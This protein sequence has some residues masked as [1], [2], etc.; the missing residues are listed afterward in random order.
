MIW[1][2]SIEMQPQQIA[3]R[4]HNWRN[5]QIPECTWSIS[6]NAPFRTEM[7]IFLQNLEH[8]GIG[9]ISILGFVKLTV[10]HWKEF[11][12]LAF[13]L[14]WR[15]MS[16]I[17]SQIKGN[18][19]FSFNSCS[20]QLQMENQSSVSSGIS[21]HIHILY[22]PVLLAL[23]EGNPMV[24]DRFPLQ[25][26]SK[27]DSVSNEPCHDVMTLCS[28]TAENA[29]FTIVVFSGGAK[30]ESAVLSET[31]L[32]CLGKELGPTALK[33]CMYLNVPTLTLIQ[34]QTSAQAKKWS[35][36]E[37]GSH[38]LLA[39][40][41]QREGAKVMYKDEI[42]VARSSNDMM[43]SSNG[44]IFRVTGHLCGEFTG[45]RWIPHTKASDAELWCFLWSA[46][47]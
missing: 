26:A 47:E 44:N 30:K 6:H 35:E 45:L 24:N 18:P 15:H 7:Y 29:I 23:C 40:K 12:T 34:M 19:F 22:A 1:E 39:W 21:I 46:S 31:S 36:E 4:V 3:N 16:I 28:C 33:I 37:L 20:G 41:R 14:K 2:N 9:N 38:M 32:C 25:R 13:S 42:Y 10:G 5:S 8:C 27:A 43:T 11:V 17:A